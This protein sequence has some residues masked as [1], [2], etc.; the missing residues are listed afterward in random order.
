MLGMFGVGLLELLI[1]A[2]ALFSWGGL[3]AWMLFRKG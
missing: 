2:I 1:L 3:L